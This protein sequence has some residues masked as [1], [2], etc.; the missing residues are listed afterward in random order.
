MDEYLKLLLLA[1]FKSHN[2][3]YDLVELNKKLGV[4]FSQFMELIDVVVAE[5]LLGYYN[6]KLTL[7]FK[8]RMR[9]LHS[10]MEYYCEIDNIE[11]CFYGKKMDINDPFLVR[12]FSKKKW[13]G[14]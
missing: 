11:N 12:G 6:S 14:S 4:P 2:E 8:G 5:E 3:E 9:L 1:Y 13:R 7:T 10:S